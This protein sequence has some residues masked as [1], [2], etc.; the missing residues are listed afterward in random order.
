[1]KYVITGA[2]GHI[3]K[4]LAEK[5]LKAGHNVTVI[6]RNAENINSLIDMGAKA[7]IGS[8]QD[9]EFLKKAFAGADAVYTM[10]P[11]NYNTNDMKASIAEVEKNYVFSIRHSSILAL[12]FSL[13][14][15]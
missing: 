4:P 11:P 7:A 6:G 9:V 13:G 8:V 2:A 15:S 12:G 1:M 14:E 5:L 3:S 10:S